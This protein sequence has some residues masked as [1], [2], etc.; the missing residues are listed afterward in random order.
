[1][2]ISIDNIFQG[3]QS[4][5]FNRIVSNRLVYNTCWE[6]PRIDRKLL[7]LDRD[8]EVVMLTSAGCNAL[9]YLL[10]NPKAVHCVDVNPFQNALLHLKKAFFIH[11]NHNLLWKFFGQ[12]YHIK[13]AQIFNNHLEFLLPAASRQIWENKI[14]YFSKSVNTPSFYYRGT[15]GN[16]ALYLHRLI[17]RK[18]LHQNILNLLNSRSL[19]EQQY[20][21]EEIDPNIWSTFQ[22]WLLKRDA[23]MA[24]LGVPKTQRNMIEDD[25]EGGLL[26]FVR[27]SI[28]HVFTRVPIQDNYFWR[29]YLTGSYTPNCSPD[30]LKGEFFDFLRSKMSA[31]STYTQDVI[32][33][34]EKRPGTYSHFVLLDHQDWMA[35]SHSDLLSREW[36]LI[37][38][39]G[40]P[41]TRILFRS[42]GKTRKFLPDFVFDKVKFVS[43][44]DMN[45]HNLHRQDR[46]GTYGS[47]HLGIIQ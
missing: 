36:K 18:G 13:A 38:K 24:M 25:Y 3:I 26:E 7:N 47:T 43:E 9:A 12:G 10:D 20:Y 30:Y 35:Q 5:F 42:A 41:G 40:R 32:D 27:S 11:G 28:R 16:I 22:K 6:D 15:S 1:M 4:R 21:F 44:E 37:L 45:I 29:V 31:I 17:S 23:T 8:S 34:L 33:F 19:P 2:N 14:H 46:V 39:N